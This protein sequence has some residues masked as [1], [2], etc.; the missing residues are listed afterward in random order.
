[1]FRRIIR[2]AQASTTA[3]TN[4]FFQP[5]SREFWGD[6]TNFSAEWNRR[7]ALAAR[8][9]SP[10]SHVLDLGCGL[11]ALRQYLPDRCVYSPADLT[12]WSNNVVVVDL[13][14][15]EFPEGQYDYIVMLGVIEYLAAVSSVLHRA[16][17]AAANLVISYCHPAG[18]WR[19][20]HRREARWVNDFSETELDD[21]LAAAGWEIVE[22]RRYQDLP[23]LQQVI[24]LAR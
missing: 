21:M 5:T 24:Y 2:K 20:G 3:A 7:A 13:D 18:D 1:M 16:R 6:R 8:F 10:G 15:G 23:N 12:A 17:S 19:L 22:K 9:V 14:R 11:M 4:R